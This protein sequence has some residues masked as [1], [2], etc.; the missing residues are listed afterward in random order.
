[1]IIVV[2]MHCSS[3]WS[4]FLRPEPA[5]TT[6]ELFWTT[7][8]K[9][10]TTFSPPFNTAIDGIKFKKEKPQT[11]TVKSLTT[12]HE[13]LVL[14]GVFSL[15]GENIFVDLFFSWRQESPAPCTTCDLLITQIFIT[16]SGNRNVSLYIIGPRFRNPFNWSKLSNYLHNEK[17][18]LFHLTVYNWR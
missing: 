9:F 18:C 15:I 11:V 14:H 2:I 17:F 5:V 7:V 12:F 10:W 3:A 8:C 6:N 4:L 1:M 16:V 13:G